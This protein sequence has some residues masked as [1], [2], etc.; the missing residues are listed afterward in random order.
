MEE[1]KLV[2]ADAARPKRSDPGVDVATGVSGA[3]LGLEIPRNAERT[4]FLFTGARRDRLQSGEFPT[5]FFYGALELQRAGY[6]L[7]FLEEADFGMNVRTHKLVRALR[8][9]G[10]DLL[11]LDLWRLSRLASPAAL[12]RLNQFDAILVSANNLA[13]ELAALKGLGLLRP[14]LVAILMG[15]LPLNAGRLAR[16]RLRQYLKHLHFVVLSR[17]EQ[18]DQQQRVGPG[19]QISYL[20]F[21]IDQHF[22]HPSAAASGGD[23]GDYALCIG[24]THRDFAVLSEAWEP[25][26]PPL[27]IVTVRKVPPSRGR[28]EVIAGDWRSAILSD[29]GIRELTQRAR[30]VLV[31][32]VQTVHPAGQSAT[33]QAMA[34]GKPTIL[35]RSCGI[36]DESA[37]IHRQTCM[38]VAPGSVE[39]LRGA[40]RELCSDASLCKSMG[41]RAR[42]VVT[43]GYNCER[44]ARALGAILQ[45]S[46]SVASTCH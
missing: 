11:H 30:F 5:E 10:F 14:R 22:W 21:G 13:L 18:Q 12:R 24:N 43:N 40:V 4:A 19:I 9:A 26:F 41:Q 32:L 35:T 6:P 38:L 1:P 23:G 39:E 25:E 46:R 17:G 37:L 8:K 33:L 15:I 3:G 20:P 16:W 28:V 29:V 31:P 45:E 42:E 44:M 27:K 7:E 36:W 2:S 34:C